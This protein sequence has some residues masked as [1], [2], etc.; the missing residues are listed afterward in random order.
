[1]SSFEPPASAAAARAPRIRAERG[2]DRDRRCRQVDGRPAVVGRLPFRPR[3]LYMG[4]NLD[5]S[6]VMLPTTRAALP[7]KRRRG[8]RPD[9][10]A[11]GRI[12]RAGR[13]D[14]SRCCDAWS[15]SANWLAEEGY[16][17]VLARRPATRQVVVFDRHFFCDYYASDVAPAGTPAALD[18]RIHGSCSGAGIRDPT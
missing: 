18:A 12:G 5:A 10:T 13:S 14:R 8:R 2:A 3:Y 15:G 7:L 17:A 6:P 4:V 1:M 16:R 9:M 11:A